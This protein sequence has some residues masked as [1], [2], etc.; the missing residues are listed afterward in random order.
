MRDRDSTMTCWP[1]A[2]SNRSSS[3]ARYAFTPSITLRRKWLK[4]FM[5]KTKLTVRQE[6]RLQGRGIW[7]SAA[8]KAE[9]DRRAGLLVKWFGNLD[10]LP[11]EMPGVKSEGKVTLHEQGRRPHTYLVIRSSSCKNW[12][13][14][15]SLPPR[16]RRRRGRPSRGSGRRRR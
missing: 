4:M 6:R 10:V 9:F 3:M 16:R 15:A 8:D 14:T 1:R 7:A 13:T 2:G 12:A 5:P 11:E